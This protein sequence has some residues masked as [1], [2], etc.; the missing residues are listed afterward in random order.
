M[1]LDMRLSAAVAATAEDFQ[2]RIIRRDVALNLRV[3]G[4]KPH[5][6]PNYAAYTPSTAKPKWGVRELLVQGRCARE[7]TW[8]S[9]VNGG[10]NAL[11]Q[12]V[13]RHKC[14]FIGTKKKGG[15]RHM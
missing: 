8:R 14:W 11:L 2:S 1:L 3:T 5:P 6:N 10:G 9:I 4:W 7:L 15:V 13:L 12:L